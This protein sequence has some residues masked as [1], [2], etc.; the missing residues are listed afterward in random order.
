MNKAMKTLSFLL[1]LAAL[2]ALLGGCAS[3]QP[4]LPTIH[5][6][7][8]YQVPI[9]N[10][11]AQASTGPQSLNINAT[12]DVEVQPGVPLYYQISSPVAVTVYLYEKIGA[13][14]GGNLLGQMQLPA[15]GPTTNQITPRTS[16]LEFVFSASQANSSGTLQ[17][18]LSDQPIAAGVAPMGR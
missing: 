17:F 7:V 4:P 12:Q 10:T 18:T 15:G 5:Y 13:A 16:S 11:S 14:P 3:P 1:P 6:P 2:T 9:G 8:T